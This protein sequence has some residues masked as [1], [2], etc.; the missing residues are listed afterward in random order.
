MSARTRHRRRWRQSHALYRAQSRLNDARLLYQNAK[1]T[2][3]R[4]R[5]SELVA[6]ARNMMRQ[7]DNTAFMQ[8]QWFTT[9][10]AR[11]RWTGV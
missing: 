2:E 1:G 11:R 3:T 6:R 10:T 5:A 7:A 4:A 9:K 8:G